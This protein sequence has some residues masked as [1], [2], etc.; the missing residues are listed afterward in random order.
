MEQ[1]ILRGLLLTFIN[2][3][4]GVGY[5]E[6]TG[7]GFWTTF[8][9]L[10]FHATLW[11]FINY[12]GIGY[13]LVRSFEKW[14]LFRFLSE[15]IIHIKKTTRNDSRQGRIVN[16]LVLKGK[17]TTL[18]LGFVP[19]IPFLPSATIIAAR[20][21][22]IKPIPG[23]P[24][25]FISILVRVFVLCCAVFFFLNPIGLLVNYLSA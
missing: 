10:T 21:I 3:W 24:I 20:L 9:I 17:A 16:W 13:L 14:G 2:V 12:Y 4:L 11:L 19:I 7:I 1:E 5:C 25:F 15:K 22:G 18:A 8:S 6:R 23:L